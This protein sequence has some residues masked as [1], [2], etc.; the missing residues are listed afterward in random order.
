M[1]ATV[2]PNTP[3]IVDTPSIARRVAGR[4]QAVAAAARRARRRATA[5]VASTRAQ[6]LETAGAGAVVAGVADLWRPGG[7]ALVAGILL[8]IKAEAT[9]LMDAE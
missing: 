3:I 2:P 7:A 8:I 1:T 4:A 6:L 9:G 5:A